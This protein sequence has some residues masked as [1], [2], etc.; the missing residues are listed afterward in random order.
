MCMSVTAA[1]PQLMDACSIG[2]SHCHPFLH[3]PIGSGQLA[4]PA[5]SSG[6][7]CPLPA[8]KVMR[9]VGSISPCP[10]VIPSLPAIIHHLS[11]HAGLEVLFPLQSQRGESLGMVEPCNEMRSSRSSTTMSSCPS[12]CGGQKFSLRHGEAAACGHGAGCGHRVLLLER[13]RPPPEVRRPCS[14]PH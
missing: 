7:A 2:S 5:G 9:D 6:C 4:V 13:P 10:M 8:H 14:F 12:A 11:V 1:S 3:V